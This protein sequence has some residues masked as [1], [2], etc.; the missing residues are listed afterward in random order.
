MEEFNN[1]YAC[2][3]ASYNCICAAAADTE[4]NSSAADFQKSTIIPVH[5]TT[6][7]A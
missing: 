2:F 6:F 3:D 1:V 4:D 5:K 7:L